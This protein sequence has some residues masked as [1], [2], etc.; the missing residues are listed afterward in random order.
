MAH[1]AIVLPSLAYPLATSSLS[2]KEI[3]DIQAPALHACLSKLQAPRTLGRHPVHAL[4]F[5]GGLNLTCLYGVQ[6]WAQ[7]DV[8]QHMLRSNQ[9]QNLVRIALEWVQLW[10]GTANSILEDVAT[11]LPHV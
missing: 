7:I 1:E 10:A 8:L 3:H 5:L 2:F 9:D 6:C 4:L 11:A